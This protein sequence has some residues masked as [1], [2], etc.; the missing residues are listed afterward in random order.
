MVVA[1]LIYAPGILWG[2]PHATTEAG[3]RGWDVDSVTAVGVLSEFHNLLVEAKEDWWVAYPLFHYFV[4]AAAYVP[5]LG[6]L[7]LTGGLSS[8]S[9]AFP[10]GFEDPEGALT[11]LAVLG[12]LVTLLMGAGTVVC[13]YL[14]GRIAW[15]VRAGLL[16][17]ALLLMS[18]PMVYYSRTG[19]LDV[20]VLFWTAVGLTVMALVFRDGL[21]VRNGAALGSA[22]ALAVATKDQA[23]GAWV[24][25]LLLVGII[26]FRRSR[27]TTGGEKGRWWR[28][29]SAVVVGGMAT[30][31][32]A[33]GVLFAPGR[34]AAHVRFLLNYEETFYN[35]AQLGLAHP[36]T[37]VGYAMLLRD[38]V[39]A[40]AIA[41]GPA[42][43]ALALLSPIRR[44]VRTSW[45][46]A[47]GFM[48]LGYF[49]LVIAP[50]SHMQ[51]RYALFPTL[52]AALLGG[53]M[54]AGWFEG[55]RFHR[56]SA[57]AAMILALGW[58]AVQAVDLTYQM[59]SDARG[60]AGR[61]L[62]D[63][64]ST[65]DAVGYFGAV[66]QLPRI[67]VGM[68]AIRLDETGVPPL[69]KLRS[70]SPRY[71][72]AIADWSS[73]PGMDRSLFLPEDV[74]AELE[75]GSLGYEPVLDL[76]PARLFGHSLPYLA[77]VNP[78][79]RVYERLAR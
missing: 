16:S 18:T 57:A 67:P 66:S 13:V 70:A 10:Y 15:N 24:P 49:V 14:A 27:S 3:I 46:L 65:G 53:R 29:A 28:P 77:F 37:A 58:S 59:L 20:P 22:A 26:H 40:I 2:L 4:L 44:D 71:V 61:W 43:V 64:G 36:K 55:K 34:F 52:V 51:Y 17:A 48:V 79:V 42:L 8:P 31:L 19:N 33:N 7:V 32:I 56:G 35:V 30:Y 63:R 47:L 12:R 69:I 23:Y 68:R 50:V 72:L 60:E 6:Y 38:F 39:W 54:V 45:G 76:R 5:Y 62:D 11:L 78:R 74:L 1:L 21:S 73:P 25:A 9:S 41:S 75:D